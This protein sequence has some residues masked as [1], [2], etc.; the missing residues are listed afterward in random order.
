MKRI[1]HRWEQR[2][3]LQIMGAILLLLS[4]AACNGR[5]PQPDAYTI[6]V[7]NLSPVLDPVLAGFKEGMT[8]LGYVEGENVTY[9]YDGATADI[10]ALTPA[11]EKVVAADVDLI[12]SISTPATMAVQQA[13]AGTDIPVVFASIFDPVAVNFVDSLRQPGGNLTGVHWGIGEGRR[14]EWLLQVAPDVTRIYIPYN[15]DDPS[16]VL[17]LAQMQK[18]AAELGVELVVREARTP[19]EI[20]TAVAQTPADVDA[21]IMLPDSMVSTRMEA[22]AQIALERQIPFSVP[23][24]EMVRDGGLIAFGFSFPASGRQAARLADQ[25]FQGVAPAELPVETDEFFLTINL[26]IAE[27]IGLYIPND[28]LMQADEIVRPKTQQD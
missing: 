23:T 6:G 10:A 19:A 3:Y 11:A 13:T 8:E 1:S 5:N 26:D 12:L 20:D 21:L 24:G 15:P 9:L 17:A 27:Q 25:I 22:M 16:P 18:M 2:K 28:I 14:L 4:A 7:V